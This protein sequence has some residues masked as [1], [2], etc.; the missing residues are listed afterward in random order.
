MRF[1]RC[2][3]IMSA[4]SVTPAFSQSVG[5]QLVDTTFKDQQDS[6][7][8]TFGV[9]IGDDISFAGVRAAYALIDDLKVF[10]DIGLTHAELLEEEDAGMGIAA[11]FLVDLPFDKYC[12]TALRATYYSNA[13]MNEIDIDGYT[14]MLTTVWDI[15]GIPQ[16]GFFG[17]L[18]IV[19]DN[20]AVDTDETTVLSGDMEFAYAVGISWTLNDNYTLYVEYDD[21][22]QSRWGISIAKLY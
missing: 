15:P 20:I 14:A 10:A 8:G 18:G 1:F 16:A 4:L 7:F 9:A 12:D 22:E 2:L 13:F 6:T 19:E 3:L 17:G 5:L 21:Y 11:G